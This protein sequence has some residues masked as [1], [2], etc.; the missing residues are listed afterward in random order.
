MQCPSCS[1]QVL[2]GSAFC[3]ECG[4]TVAAAPAGVGS[5]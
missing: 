3:S 2:D 5:Q 1:A 4:A